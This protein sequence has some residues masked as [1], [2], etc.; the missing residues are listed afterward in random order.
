MLVQS[1]I[2]QKLLVPAS[3][4]PPIF[5]TQHIN[6]KCDVRNRNFFDEIAGIF[7]AEREIQGNLNMRFPIGNIF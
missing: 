1:L 2:K 7:K 6:R 3:S 4:V 5:E